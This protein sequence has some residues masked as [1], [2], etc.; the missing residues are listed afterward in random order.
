MKN[1]MM[2]SGLVLSQLATT[3]AFAQERS[4]AITHP[5]SHL[6]YLGKLLDKQP[7]GEVAAIVQSIQQQIGAQLRRDA[8]A[9]RD[10]ERERLKSELLTDK[11]S[12]SPKDKPPSEEAK[13]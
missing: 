2:I 6:E 9:A 10:A 4:F 1:S 13:P 5:Q 11:L 7:H 3:A 12:E 8:D